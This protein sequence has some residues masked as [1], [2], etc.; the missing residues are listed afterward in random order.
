MRVKANGGGGGGRIAMTT[1]LQKAGGSPQV[2]TNAPFKGTAGAIIH[3]AV[4]GGTLYLYIYTNTNP[5]TG[6][7]ESAGLWTYEDGAWAYVSTQNLVFTD[8]T[9]GPDVSLGGVTAYYVYIIADEAFP[10][11]SS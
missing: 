7:I 10:V 6:E 2:W 8:T 4:L 5:N 9:F 1:A 3:F 11:L